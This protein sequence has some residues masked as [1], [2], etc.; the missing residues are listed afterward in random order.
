MKRI[1]RG[2]LGVISVVLDTLVGNVSMDVVPVVS[3]PRYGLTEYGTM[4]CGIVLLILMI[5]IWRPCFSI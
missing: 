4:S 1:L 5:L 2:F 3:V